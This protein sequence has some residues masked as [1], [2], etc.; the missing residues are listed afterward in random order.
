M[1]R[2]RHYAADIM[3]LETR[4]ER[5]QAL[6]EVPEHLRDWVAKLVKIQFDR[7]RAQK[8]RSTQT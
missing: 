6:N 4:E 8:W 7:R 2:P 3:A 5:R 1:K